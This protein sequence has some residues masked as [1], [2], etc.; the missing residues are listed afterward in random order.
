MNK[1]EIS[2]WNDVYDTSLERYV[3]EKLMVIGSDS[4]TS[5]NRA[6][7]PNLKSNVNGTNIF[8][9][10]LYYDYIDNHTG[11]RV[12]NPFVNYLT[13][14]RKIKVY[15]EEKWYDLIIKQIVEDTAKHTF[16][17][18]CEDQYLTELSRTG[19]ELE[20][21]TELQ[22]NIGTAA[23]LV[24]RTLKGTD[25]QRLKYIVIKGKTEELYK[26]ESV[27]SMDVIDIETGNYT[28]IP[29][30]KECLLVKSDLTIDNHLIRL[31]YTSD[32]YIVDKDNIII[33][34]KE[35]LLDG[36]IYIDNDLIQI[37]ENPPPDTE[38]W[39]D[40]FVFIFDKNEATTD[41]FYREITK[42]PVGLIYQETEEPVYEVRIESNF[43]ALKNP[44]DASE[45]IIS[46]NSALIY[47]S[48][49]PDINNLKS[50]C[51]FY[52][53]GST[54]W[55]QDV[56]DM[57]VINGNCYTVDVDWEVNDQ[58]AAAKVNNEII[59]VINFATGLSRNYRA[60]R[61]V[62]SQ[63]TIY[64][65]ILER[66]VNVYNYNGGKENLLGYETTEYNDALAVVN[67]VSNSSNFANMSGWTGTDLTWKL[68]P[69]FNED[70]DLSKYETT[71]FLWLK[72]GYIYNNGIQSNRQYL[73]DGFIK[74]ERYIF[75]IKAK[76]DGVE[77]ANTAYI[78]EP[79]IIYPDI[80]SRNIDYEPTGISYFSI[81]ESSW[82]PDDEDKPN[83]CGWLEFK[84]E[85]IKS[86]PYDLILS[87]SQPFGIFIHTL[88]NCWIE[89]VQFFKE[90][91][92]NIGIGDEK[93]R[94]NPGEMNLQ[95]IVQPVWKYFYAE[96]PKDVTKNTLEYIYTSL[97][98]WEEAHPVYNNYEKFASIE[99]SQSNRFNILQ[100]IAEAFG[101]WV[102]FII[103]HDEQ[104]NI[105]YVDGAPCK[106]VQLSSEIGEDTGLS[107]VYGID[108]QSIKR[109]IKSSSISTKTIVAQNSNEFSKNGFCSIARSTQNYPRENFI[110]NFDYFVRQGLL[111]GNALNNDLY[112]NT[113]L[114]YYSNLH[115][116]NTEYMSNL[117]II[118]NKKNELTKQTAMS[119]V[120][121]Q[122]ISA[123][124]EE[125]TEIESNIVKLA[126]VT[127]FS[128][129]YDYIKAHSD[130]AKVK[131]LMNNR[132]TIETTLN[133]YKSLLEKIN[134]S[135]QILTN[136]TVE[137][138]SR[139]KEI[140]DELTELNYQFYK[141]YSR[142][143]QEGTWSSEDY[144]NDDLYYL[145]ALQVAYTSSR[146]QI[147]YDIK[148]IRLSGLEEFSFKVFGL[149]DICYIQDT[150]Y[151]GYLS[152]GFTP[153]KEAIYISEITSYFDSP[154]KDTITVQNYKTQ[155]DDLFQRITAAT[156]SLEFSEGKYNKA[157]NIINTDGTIKSSI[158]QSTFD[159][160]TDLIYGAQN[161]SVLMDNTGI[162]VTSNEDAAKQVK[163]TSG[164]L[165]VSNDGGMSWKNAIR[166][167][168]I[169]ADVITAGKLNVEQV[170]VYG[171]NAPSFFWDERG[172]S[173][174]EINSNGSTN[175][176]KYVRFDKYGMYGI[177]NQQDFT[178]TSESAIYNNADF[179]F[180]W[181]KFFMKN[182]SENSIIEIS[183]E[184]DIVLRSDGITRIKIGRVEPLTDLTNYGI[185]IRNGDG[186]LIFQSDTKK[187][188]LAGWQ[189]GQHGNDNDE[190][191]YKYLKS[192]Q[193]EMRS[194][195]A[196]G[197][198]ETTAQ[199]IEETTYE[200]TTTGS[201]SAINMRT[202]EIEQIPSGVVIYIFS[203]YIGN[204]ITA[205]TLAANY[206]AA[207]ESNPETYPNP[208]KYEQ[209]YGENCI[210]FMYGINNYIVSNTNWNKIIGKVDYITQSTPVDATTYRYN[211]TYT[212]YFTLI[213]P[214]KFTISYDAVLSNIKSRYIPPED[215]KWSIDQAGDAIFH[216]IKADGGLIAG[217]FIDS[218]KIY[219]TTNGRPDG[220]IKTQLN[221]QGTASSGGYDYSIIT[222][223][224]QSAMAT[225]GNV[226][227]ADGLINGQDIVELAKAVQYAITIANQAAGAAQTA[228][229]RANDAYNGLSG[230]SNKGHSHRYT[231]YWWNPDSEHNVETTS[232]TG[233]D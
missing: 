126:N 209:K 43:T 90:I 180:T 214:N 221:S 164:G 95:S 186:K 3:E 173:A 105:K 2:V 110:Y 7:E 122:Y 16:A 225:I 99:I 141:K 198:F 40:P 41:Y 75:R 94:I 39:T 89:D 152:D 143:I 35:Y 157:A 67:L 181:S 31:L 219:Q 104:G 96:Q 228:M 207:E 159:S 132:S 24:D 33:N 27:V 32:E 9:F 128:E 206:D 212:Y 30:G 47:Y 232:S 135:I 87:T 131:T 85:C 223:A 118:L 120:Y 54:T 208:G 218:E 69:P 58:Q 185:H 10:Y 177:K 14:E 23:D 196:I 86:V 25:W 101:C 172:I 53:N 123:A 44:N 176:S 178:P 146:P 76:Q 20:F 182:T 171:K 106:Y 26:A 200:V 174:F 137:Y 215:F 83:D 138:E 162:T 79:S 220:P 127:N 203:S 155:F 97:N 34:A 21:Q 193:L 165:F 230:K 133:M 170:T 160:N 192:G 194:N 184:Q 227:L 100:T 108:L 129:A 204:R 46:G 168:G 56:N 13:N 125:K 233:T 71:S 103:E 55:Q 109:D 222:D 201:F 153:Y 93:I 190:D 28:I 66:Y 8:N 88:E 57:L 64:N 1:Y 226:K 179:G 175:F 5:Q 74:G 4:M 142:Y 139:Q 68:S 197:C 18:T 154:E 38:I 70:T 187:T 149:G 12:K 65:N 50:T 61:Y 60:K 224:I 42:K 52:Y 72:Q 166:G 81:K 205:K 91:Y 116:L 29:S 183:T 189:L 167:D 144:Y 84:M 117:E 15:W 148:V 217:W 6:L 113:G 147:S 17:Y 124:Q 115:N 78:T 161:E 11:E 119:K 114:A 82:V 102:K 130:N 199:T 121:T 140:I 158:I 213:E 92:G 22:N 188:E 229:Q 211:T 191:M 36:D 59:F 111:D 202:D 195:G 51:Q 37:V 73:K 112:G 156:Q 48:C 216:N 210:Q 169:T 62:Q 49:A 145:D 151:F 231:F 63:K 150:D 77:P 19:F 80:S 107:F 45:E 136:A 134:Q 163:V 98:E